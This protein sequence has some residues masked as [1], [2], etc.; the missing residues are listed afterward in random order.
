MKYFLNFPQQLLLTRY[1]LE[2]GNFGTISPLPLFLKN[3]A[4][5]ATE[6]LV[7]AGVMSDECPAV[8]SARCL[9]VA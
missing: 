4:D 6:I 8:A 5:T 1:I 3:G 2:K 9:E 7:G